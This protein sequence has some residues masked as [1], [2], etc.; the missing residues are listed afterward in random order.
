MTRHRMIA[1]M[2]AHIPI[3]LYPARLAGIAIHILRHCDQCGSEEPGSEEQPAP[4]SHTPSS[5]RRHVLP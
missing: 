1:S 5:V 4:K 3:S 2:L